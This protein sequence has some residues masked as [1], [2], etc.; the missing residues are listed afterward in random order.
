MGERVQT[1][2]G[3]LGSL[4][5]VLDVTYG[6]DKS[7]VRDRHCKANLHAL[8]KLSVT[9][10][11]RKPAHRSTSVAGRRKLAFWVNDHA[12]EFLAAIDGK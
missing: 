8:R 12:L 9:L 10:L 7:L 2:W 4:H 5:W 1:H 11:K 6:G 3:V